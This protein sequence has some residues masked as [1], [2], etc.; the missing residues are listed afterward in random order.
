MKHILR[1]AASL[2]LA[3]TLAVSDS[4]TLALPR[5]SAAE[6]QN[7]Y[8]TWSDLGND[9]HFRY[10][11]TDDFDFYKNGFGAIVREYFD[12]EQVIR[13]P[14]MYL[15]E[16]TPVIGIEYDG[17]VIRAGE[18]VRHRSLTVPDSVDWITLYDFSASETAVNDPAAYYDF[19]TTVT[20]LNPDCDIRIP[21]LDEICR[22]LAQDG[23]KLTIRGIPGSDAEEFA[24]ENGLPF[25]SAIGKEGRLSYAF[26]D[27]GVI[28]TGYDGTDWYA[29][30]PQPA[31]LRIPSEIRGMPVTEIASYAFSPEFDGSIP[32][33]MYAELFI[34]DSVRTIRPYA[35]AECGEFTDVR[36]PEGTEQIG[37]G[38]FCDSAFRSVRFPDSLREIGSSAFGGSSLSGTVFLPQGVVSVGNNAFSGSQI[39]DIILPDSLTSLGYAVFAGCDNLRRLVIPREI[40]ELPQY[41]CQSCSSLQ[42]LILPDRLTA[43]GDGSMSYTGLK[44]LHIPDGCT[45]IGSNAFCMSEL[46]S[47]DLP[48]SVTEIGFGAFLAAQQLRSVRLPAFLTEIPPSLFQN[49]FSLESVQIPSG[50]K[51]IKESAFSCC[52]SLHTLDLPDSLNEIRK[53]AFTQSGLRNMTIPAAVN[54]IE[55]SVLADCSE[56][57]SVTF[58]TDSFYAEEGVFS[59]EMAPVIYG[60]AGTDSERLAQH[61]VLPFVD[62]STGLYT[63]PVIRVLYE[64]TGDHAVVTGVN[65]RRITGAVIDPE[66]EGMPVTEIRENAFAYCTELQQVFIP[67]TVT[68]IGFNAFGGCTALQTVDLPAGLEHIGQSAFEA[69]AMASAS[70]PA[71]V[72]EI[73][74][75]AFAYFQAEHFT[76]TVPDPDCVIN[77]CA[78]DPQTYIEPGSLTI[79]G[80]RN[81]TAHAYADWIHAEFRTLDGEVVTEPSVRK[82]QP[83]D[84]YSEWPPE[85]TSTDGWYTSTSGTTG[86]TGTIYTT[87]DVW[88]T[89]DTTVYTESTTGMDF[90]TADYSEWPPEETSTDGWYTSTSGTTG[91]TG[92]LYTTTDLWYTDDTTVYTESTTGMDFSTAD[93][94]TTVSGSEPYFETT[95]WTCCSGTSYPDYTDDTTVYTESTTGM[96]FSTADSATTVSGSEPYFETTETI[97]YET[98]DVWYTD[99]TNYTMVYTETGTTASGGDETETATSGGAPEPLPGDVDCS[100]AVT[101]GDAVLLARII[102]EDPGVNPAECNLTNADLNGDGFL[103]LSDLHILLKL[104]S[105][106]SAGS[107]L[108]NR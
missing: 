45:R 20:V 40:T 98:T 91:T 21:A 56:L 92:T 103:L 43:I 35:F 100:G 107:P 93:S 44:Y 72:G 31:S 108:R 26:D 88:Y 7:W 55:S 85:E 5:I 52:T 60:H 39:T 74:Y 46:Q 6:I 37:T 66:Y 4:G 83:S 61:Y 82:Y 94:A 25:E 84:N 38:T 106:A 64:T 34:P 76:L 24:A 68:E 13:V 3:L 87:T 57:A 65:T 63:P 53:F 1:P 97:Y 49:C 104:L 73:G 12:D 15:N 101:I 86:T 23:L 78:G 36:L 16:S 59:Y 96:D 90:S 70:V 11:A 69:H 77:E 9:G 32:D 48:D 18:G 50:V 95:E 33:G 71:S 99:Y 58:L 67:E 102:A 28:I 62:L 27:A 17:T 79:C 42:E 19:I 80:Y 54:I 22:L 2:L 51:C 41:L 105:P 10:A 81:S 29:D 8:Q 89:D 30:D 47:V 14:A 75:H